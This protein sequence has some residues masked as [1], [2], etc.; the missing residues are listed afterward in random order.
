MWRN[1]QV[2]ESQAGIT[3]LG[4][5]KRVKVFEVGEVKKVRAKRDKLGEGPRITITHVK[6]QAPDRK[7]RLLICVNGP[8]F[9]KLTE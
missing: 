7:F 6:H 8:H 9:Y 3:L 4:L 5:G 1:K 2:Q